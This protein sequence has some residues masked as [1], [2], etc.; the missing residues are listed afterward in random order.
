[1]RGGD[2][3]R[4]AQD[5]CIAPQGG[6]RLCP[7]PERQDEDAHTADDHSGIHAGRAVTASRQTIEFL[8]HLP[9]PLQFLFELIDD[10][11]TPM[12]LLRL[13]LVAF[14]LRFLG[15]SAVRLTL[16]LSLVW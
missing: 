16:L 13:L 10:D 12:L 11:R 7:S 4:T 14:A 8:R 3:D 6:D 5:R 15:W 2:T 9:S 1:M